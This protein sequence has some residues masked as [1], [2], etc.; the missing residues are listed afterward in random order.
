MRWLAGLLLLA[1]SPASAADM[2]GRVSQLRGEVVARGQDSQRSLR[3]GDEVHEGDTIEVSSAGF[4]QLVMSDRSLL[5]LG[6]GARV[7]LTA[8]RAR[9]ETPR[10]ARLKVWLGKLWARVQSVASDERFEVETENAVAGVRGTEFVVEAQ[11][12]GQALVTVLQGRVAVNA[13]GEELETLLGAGEQGMLAPGQPLQ[14]V[15]LSADD[16]RQATASLQAPPR[17][18]DAERE[19]RMSRAREAASVLAQLP[20]APRP[21]PTALDRLDEIASDPASPL[22]ELEPTSELTRLRVDLDLRP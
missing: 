5:D 9:G 19:A 13:L 10:K 1:A 6:A 4:V 2:G 18:A 8:Y 16:A 22:V 20:Q 7:S 17:L 11:A 3:V 12:G 14:V 21:S 15:A